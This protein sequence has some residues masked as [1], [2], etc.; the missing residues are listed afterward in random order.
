MHWAQ[1]HPF[2]RSCLGLFVALRATAHHLFAPPLDGDAGQEN[3]GCPAPADCTGLRLLDG[4]FLKNSPKGEEEIR[5]RET[6]GEGD[7]V[8]IR[9][10]RLEGHERIERL[11]AD[12]K[13]HGSPGGRTTVGV[14][15]GGG[16]GRCHDRTACYVNMRPL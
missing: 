13:A 10:V 7:D 5:L 8:A 6:V 16:R 4:K 11:E 14:G 9:V 12:A 15:R 2:S 1:P 3:H